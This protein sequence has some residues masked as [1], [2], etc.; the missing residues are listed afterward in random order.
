M[1]RMLC[2]LR[3]HPSLRARMVDGNNV[4]GVHAAAV[5]C[6]I[7]SV[8]FCFVMEGRD[9][10]SSH[11]VCLWQTWLPYN[12][13][14]LDSSSQGP[15]CSWIYG[16]EQEGA[17]T[18]VN[19]GAL[20]IGRTLS[21]ANVWWPRFPALW[22][23]GAI[24]VLHQCV[25][26]LKGSCCTYKWNKA[27]RDPSRCLWCN[28]C[29]QA[30]FHVKQL[31]LHS[32]GCISPSVLSSVLRGSPEHLGVG[33]DA[34]HWVL[35]ASKHGCAGPEC[36]ISRQCALGRGLGVMLQHGQ[37]PISPSAFLFPFCL[38]FVLSKLISVIV[39]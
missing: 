14:C 20:V 35:C 4:F 31:K 19:S 18:S 38:R 36:S 30:H 5:F 10:F 25:V 16:R 13:G 21:A 33:S 37:L 17:R 8:T 34:R 3:S 12:M 9:L 23:T 6:F 7:P 24:V 22:R 26:F 1:A 27:N 28:Q 29:K 2:V 39:L 32:S 11:R 15:L